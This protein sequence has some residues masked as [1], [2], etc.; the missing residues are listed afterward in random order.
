MSIGVTTNCQLG[1]LAKL[2]RVELRRVCTSRSS[3]DFADFHAKFACK[4]KTHNTKF[5]GQVHE[6]SQP[7]LLCSLVHQWTHSL[8]QISLISIVRDSAGKRCGI[9]C[10]F[11]GEFWHFLCWWWV[12]AEPDGLYCCC[13]N[14]AISHSSFDFSHRDEN[15]SMREWSGWKPAHQ[16]PVP[17]PSQPTGKTA[18]PRSSMAYGQVSR[19]ISL[20]EALVLWTAVLLTLWSL[21]RYRH[22]QCY[23][24]YPSAVCWRHWFCEL[25]CCSE[26]FCS[27]PTWKGVLFPAGCGLLL[28][29][30]LATSMYPYAC[31][32]YTIF[33]RY[34]LIFFWCSKIG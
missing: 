10:C 32:Y 22:Y 7:S 23:F 25:Q 4:P 1:Q 17:Q 28:H 14:E 21:S 33:S 12:L 11:A 15:L 13:Y 9:P 24:L 27:L 8:L 20:L 3:L 6:A 2:S 30:S 29:G 16:V 26:Q 31:F 19:S 34:R 5:C 18:A